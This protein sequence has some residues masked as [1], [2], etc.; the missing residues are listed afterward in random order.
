[1][2][3]TANS[4]PPSIEHNVKRRAAKLA[5]ALA[6][7]MILAVSSVFA[8]SLA[9]VSAHGRPNTGVIPNY[10][11]C[12]SGLTYTTVGS[13]QKTV[14]A[15]NQYTIYA[16]LQTVYYGST[17]CG[18]LA[19]AELDQ[20]GGA[21]G[22]TLD[23]VLAAGGTEGTL[24]IPDNNTQN[25]TYKYYTQSTVAGSGAGSSTATTYFFQ[26]GL[27]TPWSVSASGSK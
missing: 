12:T 4:I 25:T 23:A 14:G 2:N 1:M 6:L 19:K 3:D 17:F 8:G 11:L 26:N 24:S 22:G 15:T 9:S 18:F 10:Q 27:S 20:K 13:N 7:A 21:V 16:T 5:F